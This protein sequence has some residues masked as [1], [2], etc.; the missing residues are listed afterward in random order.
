MRDLL[1]R[2]LMLVHHRTA[3]ILSF[4]SL[5]TRTTGL[6]MS[7]SRLKAME[8][9]EAQELYEHPANQLIAGLQFQQIGHLTGSIGKIEQAVLASAREHATPT[10][11]APGWARFWA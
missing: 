11:S 10:R 2:R 8:I 5:Y 6:D 9:K 4:K 3:L 7:L 1:R